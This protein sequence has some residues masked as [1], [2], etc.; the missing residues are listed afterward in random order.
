MTTMIHADPVPLRVD[1]HG[2]IRI[3]E[4]RL[5]LEVLLD[6]H[7]QGMTPEA[8]ADGYQGV[9][10]LADVHAVLAYYNR[11]RDE[12]DEY[13]RRRAAEAETAR[14]QLEA[15]QPPRPG[16]REELLARQARLGIGHVAP[17]Q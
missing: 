9:I 5:S 1:A 13:L 14:G 16:F 2:V 12:V 17:D 6:Y 11:H 10:T 7:Q 15:T 3:G 4:S 8:I